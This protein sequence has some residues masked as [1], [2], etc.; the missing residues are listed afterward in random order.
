[1]SKKLT[2]KFTDRAKRAL[3]TA[4]HE[5]KALG[6]EV[7]DTEHILLGI[8]ASES[9][10]AYKVL[11]SFQVDSGRLR[12]SILSSTE[13]V[14]PRSVKGSK[15]KKKEGFSESAQEAIAAAALQAYLL[16]SVHVGTEH[17]LCGLAKT[18]SGLAYHI[19][20]TWGISYDSLKSKVENFTPI[21]Q[22]VV[23]VKEPAT[24]LLN[25][26][27]RDLTAL[28]KSDDLDPLIARGDEI[29]R[30]LQVLSRRVKN[31]PVLLG[32]AGVGKTAIV[33]GLAQRIVERDVP[34]K[35][36]D[37]RLISL[38]VNSIVAGTR[39]RGDFEERLMGIIDE[40]K[41]SGNIVY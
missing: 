39:F 30:V 33:E 9:S 3:S 27:G 24:P 22:Q 19:L 20:R 28:A 37:T 36:F 1:M 32:D 4:T 25:N 21:Q 26:Y 34:Q 18:P 5:A 31:N 12:E 14:D 17:I 2:E 35:F 40:I 29:A 16:G 8:L 38:D 7:V 41:E 6:S 11:S 13:V 15:N 10:V 23:A